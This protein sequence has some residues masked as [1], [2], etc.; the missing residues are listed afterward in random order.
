MDSFIKADI[1]FMI[2]TIGTV[3]LTVLAISIG[4]YVIKILKNV[5]ESTDTFKD[6]IKAAGRHL[7]E[8]EKEITDSFIFK[9]IF[10]KRKNKK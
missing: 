7:G 1:F 10:A 9:F 6:E 8:I 3:V 2:A 5:K 4:Y